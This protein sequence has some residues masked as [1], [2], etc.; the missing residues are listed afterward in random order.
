[1]TKQSVSNSDS[2]SPSSNSTG[3][4]SSRCLSPIAL[5]IVAIIGFIGTCILAFSPMIQ[6]WVQPYT[7]APVSTP[8]FTATFTPTLTPTVTPTFTSTFTPVPTS[9]EPTISISSDVRDIGGNPIYMNSAPFQVKVSGTVS[10]AD[11]YY[12]YLIVED[13]NHQYIQPKGGINV[14]N[15]FSIVCNLG[16]K[17]DPNSEGVEYRL[18]AVITDR[19]Y[20]PFFH[21]EN[22][23]YIAKS[24][25]L[26]I[27]RERLLTLT[28]AP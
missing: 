28:P 27:T 17:D 24:N 7:C 12:I 8:T 14:D 6:C 25:K 2:D 1:M 10:N 21:F 4:K 11:G 9:T 5:I 3:N 15:D 19:P 22:E 26:K 20:S 23:S 13:S 16:I 18:Y